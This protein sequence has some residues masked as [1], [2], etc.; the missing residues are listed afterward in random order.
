MNRK[1]P[2]KDLGPVLAY[3]FQITDLRPVRRRNTTRRHGRKRPFPG[4]KV[5]IADFYVQELRACAEAIGWRFDAFLYDALLEAKWKTERL[6][7]VSHGG[8]VILSKA[9]RARL[10]SHYQAVCNSGRKFTLGDFYDPRPDPVPG[11]GEPLAWAARH[12]PPIDSN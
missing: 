2:V 1:S 11:A 6:F 4:V 3:P 9:D 8:L 10:S 12:G 7:G 5:R